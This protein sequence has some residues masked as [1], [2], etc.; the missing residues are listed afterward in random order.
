MLAGALDLICMGIAITRKSG[1]VMYAN[2]YSKKLLATHALAAPI[3]A[4][5]QRNGQYGLRGGLAEFVKE[6]GSARQIWSSPNG[7][8]LIEILPL[9]ASADVLGMLG[10]RGGAMLM[11]R[12]R[13]KH[14][15]PAPE[16]LMALFGFSAAEARTCLALCQVES[17]EKCAS[18]LNLSLATVRSQL[19]AAMQ[20]TDTSK[21][22]E[23]LSVILSVPVCRTGNGEAP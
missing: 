8:L 11:M 4:A 1:E 15:L 3:P 9:P 20:K 19:Q 16:H 14:P 2:D 10:R 21:Q 17:A 6:I 18:R 7:Q 22:G 5:E 12:E 23:L 13:G